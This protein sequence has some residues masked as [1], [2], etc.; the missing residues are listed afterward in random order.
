MLAEGTILVPLDRSQLSDRSPPYANALDVCLA[1]L[2]A[3]VV[4]MVH[5]FRAWERFP[6]Y[7]AA[8]GGTWYDFGF[9]V[10]AG[11]PLLA[12]FGKGSVSRND[13]R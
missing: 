7:N 9:L 10:G 12:I 1:G 13:S 6:F 3:W 11:S 4:L 8:R 2:S 5:V